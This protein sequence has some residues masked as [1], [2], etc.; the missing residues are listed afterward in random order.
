MNRRVERVF[1]L[2]FVR[3]HILHHACAEPVFGRDLVAELARHG[4]E[5]SYGTIY[6]IL[7]SMEDQGLLRSEK[8]TVNGK[9]RRYYRC[10]ADGNTILERAR[11]SIRELVDEV[12]P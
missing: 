1:F 8:K 3:V 7:H 11:R 5:L 9:M 4:Y 6:P 2:G 10:T 12:L